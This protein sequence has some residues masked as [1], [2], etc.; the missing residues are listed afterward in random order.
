MTENDKNVL[1]EHYRNHLLR[2]VE[3][4]I[5]CIGEVFQEGERLAYCESVNLDSARQYCRQII[6]E[7]LYKQSISNTNKVPNLADVIKAMLAIQNQIDERCQLLLKTHLKSENKI[8]QI[9]ELKT[10]G[11][12]HSTTDVFLRYAEL[13]RLL[14]DALAYSPNTQSSGQDP[15]LSLVI[16]SQEPDIKASSGLSI[17]LKPLIFEALQH[18]SKLKI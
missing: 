2:Y 4:E 15:F 16:N 10:L 12:F 5:L 6:D 14:C 1:K 11:R 9:D 7:R 17:S 8:M 13:A 3:N 18:I